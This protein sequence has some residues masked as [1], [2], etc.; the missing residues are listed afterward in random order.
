MRNEN[1]GYI[2]IGERHDAYCGAVPFGIQS[3]DRLRHSYIIGQTGTGKSTLLKSQILQSI[4]AGEGV[5]F[6]DPHGDLAEDIIEHIPPHRMRD[7]VYFDPT[8]ADNV[9]ALNLLARA[10]EHERDRVTSDVAETFRYL[11][12]DIWGHGRMNYV[13]MNTISALLDYPSHTGVSL[14]GIQRMYT[15]RAYRKSITKHCRN[16]SVKDFWKIEFEGFSKQYQAEATG[17]IQNKIGQFSL[18]KRLRN[19]IGQT[20]S[21]IDTDYIMN[22]Q[23]I[24][25]ANLSKGHIGEHD[26]NLLGSLLVTSF[27]LSAMRRVEIPEEDR[28]SFHLFLDEFQSFK[29]G[30]FSS[31]LSEARKFGLSITIGHQFMAQIP[32]EIKSAI[33]GNVGTVLCFRVS[34]EDA[35]EIAPHIECSP[36]ALTELSNGEVGVRILENGEPKSFLGK[37]HMPTFDW[38]GSGDKIRAYSRERYTRPRS[39]VEEKIDRWSR[40]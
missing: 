26:A 9:P 39:E 19:I 20:K 31:I 1:D 16:Q 18:S 36:S 32:E 17:A 38:L 3:A 2:H 29:T 28:T 4:Y 34:V 33:L 37:T 15:D 10:P 24:L 23:K 27:K 7:V 22:N 25:I 8:D 35:K 14:L 6:L 5:A 21:T 12:A 13:L 40:G 30:A 11:W